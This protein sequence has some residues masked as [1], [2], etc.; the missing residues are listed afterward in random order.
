MSRQFALYKDKGDGYYAA[1]EL[2]SALI[3]YQRALAFDEGN[4]EIRLAI[5]SVERILEER[6]QQEALQ[7]QAERETESLIDNTYRQAEHLY[8]RKQYPAALDLLELVFDIDPENA[9]AQSLQDMIRQAM[10]AEIR[11][12]IATAVQAEEA[13]DLAAAIDAYNRVLEL[14]PSNTSILEAKRNALA[15]L[16]LARQLKAA[17]QFYN[18][19]R[20]AEARKRLVSI[21]EVNPNESVAR[22]YLD[23][24]DAQSQPTSQSTLEELQRDKDIW[25]VYLE[26]LRHMRNKEYRKAIEAWEQV[27]KKYP[28]NANTLD[29]IEQA[30]LRLN[31]EQ[32]E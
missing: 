26:G 28:N 16:D 7:R 24:I 29:N 1:D 13:G 8:Q 10:A 18:E 19:G 27:L 21:L 9:R 12:R 22:E 25:P 3:Y 17:I 5:S 6:R 31:A 2:D 20:L 4:E 32:S 14:D 15:S 11:Q 23:R 30:R